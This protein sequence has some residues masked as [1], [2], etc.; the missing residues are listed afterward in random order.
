MEKRAN[1][2]YNEE[3]AGVL[4][5][6][7]GEYIFTY[8]ENYRNDPRKPAVSLSFP[9]NRSEYRSETLF[10]FFFGLLAEGENKEIQCRLLYIDENDHFTRLIKTAGDETI[11]AITVREI[12]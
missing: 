11:G 10:P 6:K 1:V 5:K 9:K 3:L 4:T 2:Y 12:S 7:N 8:D